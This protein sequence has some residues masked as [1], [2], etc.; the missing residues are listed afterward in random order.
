MED[1]LVQP[2]QLRSRLDAGL[3]REDPVR[4]P[5]Q[6][7]RKQLKIGDHLVMA[8]PLYDAAGAKQGVAHATCSVT[9]KIRNGAPP[10]LCSGIVSMRDG[11]I[12][13]LGRVLGPATNRLAIVGGT[14]AYAGARGNFTSTDYD[15][16][17]T[18]V[19]EL[20]P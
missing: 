14:G 8:L 2:A 15:S 18:D 9:G 17:S 1:R 4:G 11:D 20:L 19:L 12:A 6:H 10:V 3:L 5:V 16:G 13:V 7:K